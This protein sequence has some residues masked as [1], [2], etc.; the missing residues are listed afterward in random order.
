MQNS[1]SFQCQ[2]YRLPHRC[3]GQLFVTLYITNYQFYFCQGEL[4]EKPRHFQFQGKTKKKEA[5]KYPFNNQ[6]PRGSK[7]LFTYLPMQP[8]STTKTV[9]RSETS[10]LSS[11]LV[12]IPQEPG[13]V[14]EVVHQGTI[15]RVSQFSTTFQESVFF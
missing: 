10:Q 11:V 15:Y 4:W 6:W 8:T 7:K 3:G 12:T 1:L 5:A 14:A 9:I 13:E 2:L